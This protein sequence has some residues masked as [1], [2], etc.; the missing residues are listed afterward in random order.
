MASAILSVNLSALQA[1]YQLLK[2]R[3]AKKNVAAVVKANAY[4]LGVSEVSNA[5][6]KIGCKL[7]FVA[8]LDEAIELRAVLPHADIAVFNGIFENE[9][10]EYNAHDIIPVVNDVSQFQFKTKR[11]PIVHIDTGMTRLGLSEYDLRVLGTLPGC[12]MIISHLS[13]ANEPAH[14]KNAE[15]LARLT[16]ALA[17]HAP[18]VPVS[19]ANSSGHFLP[20]EFHF[21]IGRP[22]CALY[23][24]NP[25]G[26]TNPMQPVA[27]LSASILQVR[28]LDRD[29]AVGYGATVHA[30]KESRIAVVGLGYSDGYFRSLS[31]RGFAFVAHYKVPVLGRISMDMIALDV[32]MVPDTILSTHQHIEF[33]N[34]TQP[35]DDI[36]AQCD[37]I[38]YEVFTRLGRRVRRVYQS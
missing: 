35:V 15:Q 31:N 20:Q 9:I 29:E 1:N 24:I 4:G 14:P 2:N 6:A 28:T 11:K 26:G 33:I 17:H 3:H 27:T 37:T 8:T 19:F 5:L 25:T 36:A 21:D 22:G 13:C 10:G 38:G 16:H 23:G 12:E 18:K 30:E 7:F 32:S 34:E